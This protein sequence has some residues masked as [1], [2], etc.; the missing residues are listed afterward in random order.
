MSA[1]EKKLAKFNYSYPE[2]LIAQTPAKPRDAARLL[3]YRRKTGKIAHSVFSSLPDFLPRGALLIFNK[4]KVLPARL[5]LKK[6]SGGLVRILYLSHDKSLVKALADRPL[7]SGT[8]L[9]LAEKISFKVSRR[10]GRFYYLN[11]SFPASRI[12]EV[13]DKFGIAPLPP[14]IKKS[15]LDKKR[16]REEYQSV[17]AREAGS[18]AAPTASLHFTKKLLRAIRGTG[19]KTRFITLHVGLGTFAPLAEENFA[20]NAL[21]EECYRISVGT[22]RAIRKAKSE[23]RPVIAVGTTVLRALETAFSKPGDLR[24]VGTTSLFIR[25]GYKFRAVD[26]LITNFHVPKSS[27]LM[28]VAA[29]MGRGKT[30]GAYKTAIRNGYRLFSFG[31]GMLII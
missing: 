31:D 18:V 10:E 8:E 24:L 11:P 17:F 22:F 14:Y 13:L 9:A 25:P 16:L 29:F 4:T 3:I 2:E 7:K 12:I 26:G 1:L 21:H 5:V 6:K 28:L 19:A 15:A 20:R 30:L 27:L 23:K